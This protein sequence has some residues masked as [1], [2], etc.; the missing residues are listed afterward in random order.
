[1]RIL[2]DHGSNTFENL[3]D[4]A[5]L[6]VCAARLRQHWPD[7]RLRVITRDSTALATHLKDVEPVELTY[8]GGL[9]AFR[10]VVWPR[11]RSAALAIAQRIE[12][13]AAL[14]IRGSYH[15]TL[16]RALADC[17]ILVHAGAGVL[18]DP[19]PSACARRLVTFEEATARRIP[20][21][22]F[23]Q[24][25]GPLTIPSLRS[26][27]KTVLPRMNLIGARD[28]AT[29]QRLA[30][31]FEV[32]H[33]RMRFTGDDALSLGYD[34]RPRLLGS[35]LGINARRSQSTRVTTSDSRWM[36][37]QLAA[38]AEQIEPAMVTPIAIHRSDQKSTQSM[39]AGLPTHRHG[40]R[41][42]HSV[43]ALL[44]AIGKCRLVICTSYHCA[45]L[46]L[47]QGIPAICLYRTDY[48]QAK[49]NGLCDLF[50]QGCRRIDLRRSGDRTR[51]PSLALELW[52]Q[53][54]ELRHGILR[55]AADQ[56]HRSEDAYLAF[57]ELWQ[58]GLP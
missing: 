31:E 3:G 37:D 17:D 40:P 2:V 44:R 41:H 15:R 35:E 34:Q 16:I 24:G 5:M 38:L 6:Q 51:L 52:R 39:L 46:A 42:D 11:L 20:T 43:P 57:H 1:M 29:L 45:V 18:A 10:E 47:A 26:K 32:S 58:A 36:A 22:L 19:F 12:A 4:L 23:G 49:F 9:S 53:A 21:G 54:E 28:M 48:Y 30:D 33:D 55:S 14:S 8:P 7:A 25:I 50:P 56:I 27:A 13:R